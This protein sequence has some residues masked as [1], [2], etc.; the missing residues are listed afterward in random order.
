MPDLKTL[1]ADSH[2]GAVVR[3]DGTVQWRVWAP[4]AKSVELI[5]FG[6]GEQSSKHPLSAAEHGWFSTELGGISEGQRYAYSLDGGRPIPDP[7]SRWQPEGVHSPSAVWNPATFSW[8]DAGW[9]GVP[10]H[11]LVIYE[12]HVGTFTPEGTFGAIIPRLESLRQLGITAIELMP[13][14]QC[15]GRWNWGYD[16]AYWYAVQ[17]SCG[18][19]RELQR[20]VD[21]CHAAGLAVVLDV[22]YNHLGPEGNYLGEFGHY[23]TDKYRT[24]W[25]QAINYDDRGSDQVRQFVLQNVCQW[26]RDFHVDALRLDAIHAIFDFSAQHILSD[27]KLAADEAS[28]GLPWPV[29]VIAESNLNDIRILLPR[30][31]GGDSLDAQWNDDFH[32]CI[33][34]LFTGE[35]DGYYAD[36]AAPREQLA[37]VLNDAFAFDGVY[38]P[39]RDRRHGAP[40]GKITRDRFVVSIQTHDQVGNRAAGERLTALCTPGQLR[41]GAALMLFS[42]F[43]PM[44]FM[45]EEYGERNPFPFFCDFGDPALQEA[46]RRGRKE[47]FA[48]FAWTG[49]I[50]DPCAEQTMASARLSWSWPEGSWQAGLRRLYEDL[51]RARREWPALRESRFCTAEL[52]SGPH[53]PTLLKMERRVPGRHDQRVIVYFNLS[54]HE[55]ARPDSPDLPFLLR[56]ESTRYGGDLHD[57]SQTIVLAPWEC[58]AFGHA[59]EP[60]R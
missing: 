15:P 27:I 48:D 16:G 52:E 30:E 49:E 34:T 55:T 14:A 43:T 4:R 40:A 44:L 56:T 37:K 22:V 54:P 12:L 46:V 6:A 45:G 21:A 19:P 28:S 41:L 53:G 57:D 25:G 31:G 5:L 3:S 13:V 38:S 51:L 11:E 26:V 9:R 24:P 18:G 39:F 33:H 60:T 8:T 58:L 42:P 32:H 20:L 23:F 59:T 2:C 17:N 1:T 35:L 10:L 47:E 36:F 7:A 29:H 50:P